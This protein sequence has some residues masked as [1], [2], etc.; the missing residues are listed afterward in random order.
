MRSWSLFLQSTSHFNGT[1]VNAILHH[2]S[3]QEE[4]KDSREWIFTTNTAVRRWSDTLTYMR[5]RERE[6]ESV[7]VCV[8]VSVCVREQNRKRV[9]HRVINNTTCRGPCDS[10]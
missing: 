3:A 2:L 4:R 6:R 1:H 8:C 10:M 7:Y 5:E 9:E